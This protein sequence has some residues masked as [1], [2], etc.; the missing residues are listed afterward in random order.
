MLIRG[1]IALAFGT[2]GLGIAEYVA[3]GLLPYWA[4]DF[5]VTIAQSGHAISSYALG[6]AI[7]A[8]FIILLRTLKLKTILLILIVV[9]IV[10]NVLTAFAPTF[11]TMLV[12]RF[13]AGLP[14]G[15]YFGVGSIIAQRLAAKGK[16]T[17][18]VSIM[19]AG[20]TVSNIFG[21]P[22][23]T[24]LAH[25]MSWRTI[26]YIVI[27]WG[28]LVLLAAIFWIRDVGK[29]KDTGFK[30]QFAFLRNSAPW[31]VL[32]ATMFGNAGIFCMHSYISPI[33]TDFA[34]IPLAA[35]SA[36]MAAMGVC[37][38]I[39]NLVSGRLCDRYTPGKVAF[40]C[41]LTAIIVL[42]GISALGN[43]PY[44]CVVLACI[45][46]GLLFAISS[47]EQVS[48]LRVAPGGLLLGASMVQAAFNLGNAIGAYVGGIPFDLS[49]NIRWV[50]GFGAMLAVLGTISLY[51]YYKRHEHLFKDPTEADEEVNQDAM[52]QSASFAQPSPAYGMTDELMYEYH[53]KKAAEYAAK[54]AA[55]KAQQ[56]AT[57]A[58]AQALEAQHE[59]AEASKVAQSAA[60]EAEVLAQKATAA[61]VTPEDEAQ[62]IAEVTA[63]QAEKAQAE[64]APADETQS[65][66]V[67]AD[68]AKADEPKADET[69]PD[70][71]KTDE[72][73]A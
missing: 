38:V 17:S 12:S 50:T 61:G 24:A 13:I 19:I 8:F 67:K 66:A 52:A 26:F 65:A 18:A 15:A 37:M 45:A 16:G 55:A 46:A 2:L 68:D 69:K 41:Q 1:L 33:L 22:L 36:V 42:L 51:I 70:A 71:S 25:S 3:M 72:A 64:A 53:M 9:H 31:W 35:V 5:N 34:G 43:N 63:Q 56:I 20:M 58:E 4:E 57:Q 30:G 49:L 23:G 11:E 6:V 62:A 60:Q 48:I 47:P 21:V 27:C 29:I 54:I 40:Y 59:A 32:A 28:I 73:K 44:I 10:G 7:G 39:A 14:H